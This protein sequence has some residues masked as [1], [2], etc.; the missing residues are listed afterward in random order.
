M[1]VTI[2]TEAEIRKCV[3]LNVDVIDEIE[4]AFSSITL[5]NATVPPI[6]MLEIPEARGETDVKT[7]Y[8]HGR[9]SFGIKI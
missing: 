6:L 8:I 4:N 5:G 9:E 7:A 1:R 2:L 3:H